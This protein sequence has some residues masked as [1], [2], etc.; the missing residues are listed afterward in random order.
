VANFSVGAITGEKL[1]A[2]THLAFGCGLKKHDKHIEVENEH[3]AGETGQRR[4][5]D[6][7]GHCSLQVRYGEGL[8]IKNQDLVVNYGC[9]LKIDTNKLVVDL[10]DLIGGSGSRKGLTPSGSCGIAVNPGC[11]L[12][13]SSEQ[14]QV[15]N[16]D[17]AGPGL[18]VDGTCGLAVNPGC[19]IEVVADA[20]KVKPSELAGSGLVTEGTCGL[21]VNPGCGLV[22]DSDAIAVDTSGLSN[23]VVFDAFVPGTLGV[24]FSGCEL[25]VQFQV[26]AVTLK[27][28]ACGVMI[29]PAVEGSPVLWSASADLPTS[30]ISVYTCDDECV[31]VV[32]LDC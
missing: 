12:E 9:G 14:V 13:L 30:S 21:A 23:T 16:S 19:G 18:V 20:V 10:E 27:Q 3:L 26:Q 8:T 25:T 22:I 15:K 7:Y 2:Q 32:V 17:L 24:S 29:G 11:G 28:N 5:I 4:G 6:P 1:E 31:D